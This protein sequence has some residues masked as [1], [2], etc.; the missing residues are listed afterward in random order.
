MML[1]PDNPA[2]AAADARLRSEPVIW[3]TTVARSG[4]PQSSPVW[5]LWDGTEFLS[6]GSK[7]GQKTRNIAANPRVD[8]HLDG[9]G[10]GG[11]IVIFEG[12]ARIDQEGPPAAAVADFVAKYG[13]LIESYGWTLEGVARDYPHVIR[14][15]PTRA[16]IW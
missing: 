6:Y 1:N 11:G 2:H 16:R 13:G 9:N 5:F 15:T 8:L 14:V 7:D 4:Q 3:L 10:Q 12:T